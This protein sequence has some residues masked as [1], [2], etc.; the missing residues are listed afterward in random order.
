MDSAV[1]CDAIRNLNE[2]K[3]KLSLSKASFF[4]GKDA[5]CKIK[6]FV[7][8]ELIIMN[9]V[10]Q[11]QSSWDVLVNGTTTVMYHVACFW[12]MEM[13]KKKDMF[14]ELALIRIQARVSKRTRMFTLST[15]SIFSTHDF[16]ARTWQCEESATFSANTRVAGK[17]KHSTCSLKRLKRGWV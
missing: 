16:V 5:L 7:F 15:L 11:F 4:K 3:R 1:T 17:Q 10:E 6:N 14:C 13:T 8:G 9:P 12:P 2:M